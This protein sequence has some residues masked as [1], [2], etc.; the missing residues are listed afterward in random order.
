MIRNPLVAHLPQH[1]LIQ[2][3]LIFD[4]LFL[5]RSH[6]FREPV[7]P[8]CEFEGGSLL[9]QGRS[10]VGDGGCQVRFVDDEFGRGDVDAVNESVSD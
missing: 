2:S 5:D 3:N 9:T 10:D 8:T 7:D 1:S 4:R 6:F